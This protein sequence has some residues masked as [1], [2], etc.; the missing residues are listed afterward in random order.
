MK[1][2]IHDAYDSITPI[3]SD[4]E[5]TKAVIGK[6]KN[7]EKRTF[8]KKAFIIPAA[9]VMA[10]TVGAVGVGASYNWDYAEVLESFFTDRISESSTELD[11]SFDFNRYGMAIDKT[12]TKDDCT[13]DL[14][15]I[16][17]DSSTVYIACDVTVN[18]LAQGGLQLKDVYILGGI[19]PNQFGGEMD[20][21]FSS[22]SSC[23]SRDGNTFSMI[24]PI[25]TGEQVEFPD[26][27]VIFQL[28]DFTYF[29]T[30]DNGEYTAHSI[31]LNEDIAVDMSS[32]DRN[33]DT[34]VFA[35]DIAFEHESANGNVVNAVL[36]EIR[37][38]PLS[39]SYSIY[40]DE[41]DVQ[42]INEFHDLTDGALITLS[43]GS[44]MDFSSSAMKYIDTEN[45]FVCKFFMSYPISPDEVVSITAAGINCDLG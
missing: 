40:V 32:F 41:Q 20:W 14:H 8:S 5:I 43:D 6:A 36:K 27:T 44:S 29:T 12:I 26:D 16:A 35:P 42:A 17:A 18:E 9:A 11:N 22:D 45:V 34:A 1:H 25:V 37:I 30:D 23:I 3:R 21:G 39:M 24:C 33:M 19:E 10:L 13:I 4:D 7:M 38:S 28:Y 2:L 31:T 15:G